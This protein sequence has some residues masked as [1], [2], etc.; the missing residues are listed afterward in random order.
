MPYQQNQNGRPDPGAPNYSNYNNYQQ[1]GPI[2]NNPGHPYSGSGNRYPNSYSRFGAGGQPFQ[3]PWWAIL[4]GFVTWWPLGFIFLAVNNM[5][6][7]QSGTGSANRVYPPPPTRAATRDTRQNRPG[8]VQTPPPQAAARPAPQAAPRPA[9]APAY[10]QARPKTEAEKFAAEM[11]AIK[12]RHKRDEVHAKILLVLGIAVAALGG[13]VSVTTIAE[14][15]SAAM[16]G[17]GIGWLAEDLITG[18]GFLVA[19]GGMCFGAKR[20][21]VSLR[22]RRK[23]ANI[24]GDADT[25][26]IEDIAGAIPCDYEKCCNYLEGCI[27]KGMFGENAYLDMR[28]RSLVVRGKAPAQPKGA[29]K[30]APEPAAEEK[31]NGRYHE[32]LKELRDLNERIPGEEMSDKIDRLEEVSAKIFAQAE[33]NPNKLPQMRKFMDYYLPTS[34]KLLKT[35]AELDEQGVEGDNITEAKNRIE[36]AMDTLVVAFE[37]QLDQLFETDALDVST[38]IDVI[39]NM[40]AADG[41]TGDDDPFSLHKPGV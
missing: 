1:T 14:M 15:A 10:Q 38:D 8:P 35:Y 23:I 37:K 41:L 22:M 4:M 30:K 13:L 33:A 27:A 12:A 11:A 18:L 29:E 31:P 17:V 5:L 28:T 32:I 21:R 40:L 20:M 16:S 39:E 3:F 24:V 19:G 9:A 34:M 36:Q 2:Y 26:Y 7:K 6:K 25:M